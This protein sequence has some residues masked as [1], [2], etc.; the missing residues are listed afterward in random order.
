[1]GHQE[2]D[3]RFGS[4]GQPRQ[5]VVVQY[6]QRKHA[7]EMLENGLATLLGKLKPH[8]GQLAFR[9]RQLG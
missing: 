1:V 5:N 6:D 4:Y 9:F 7:A 8:F 2:L 3:Q